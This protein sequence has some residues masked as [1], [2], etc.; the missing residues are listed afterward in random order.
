MRGAL[1]ECQKSLSSQCLLL[2]KKQQHMLQSD[3]NKNC[4]YYQ[5]YLENANFS[6]LSGKGR[7][8]KGQILKHSNGS[9]WNEFSGILLF[10]VIFTGF[11][12]AR[13]L[14]FHLQLVLE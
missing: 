7:K 13:T 1:G 8:D 12:I 3:Q 11:T 10:C 14:G 5:Y 2:Y 4:K 9:L 6:K